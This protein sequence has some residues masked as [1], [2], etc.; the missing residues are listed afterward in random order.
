MESRNVPTE[1]WRASSMSYKES[2]DET[3][4]FEKPKEL[5]QGRFARLTAM[6]VGE[7][8]HAANELFQEFQ[9]PEE[10]RQDWLNS[11]LDAD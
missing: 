2:D 5:F 3:L 8:T 11:L 10:Q 4:E 9:I 1:K 6:P 7:R